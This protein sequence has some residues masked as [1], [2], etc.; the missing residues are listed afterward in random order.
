MRLYLVRHGEA[1]SKRTYSGPDEE[2]PLTHDGRCD[3]KHLLED[4]SDEED[5]PVEIWTSPLLRAVQTAEECAVL[6]GGAE[7]RVTHALMP[8]QAPEAVLEEIDQANPD[9]PLALVGHEPQLGRLLRHLLQLDHDLTLPKGSVC[10]VRYR[11]QSSPPGKFA[12][13]HVPDGKTITSLME[14][15]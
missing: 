13:V 7:V 2:R 3:L 6:W 9:S 14:L 4:L 8:D 5:A 11:K 10:R 1:G 12:R 15:F